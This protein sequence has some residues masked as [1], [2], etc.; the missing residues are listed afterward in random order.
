M[1]QSGYQPQLIPLNTANVK[2]LSSHPYL[3]FKLANAIVAYRFQHGKFDSMDDLGHVQLMT[4][5]EIERIK[6][7]LTLNP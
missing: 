6:P 1:I 7:Y 3:S 2:E 4:K 5:A